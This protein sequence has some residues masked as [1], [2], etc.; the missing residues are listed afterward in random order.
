LVEDPSLL[1]FFEKTL[2]EYA[3]HQTKVF[4][5]ITNILLGKL[6]AVCKILEVTNWNSLT[7]KIN[8]PTKAT[9]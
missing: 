7:E 5:T 4:D 1:A 3:T 8:T 2:Q 6:E 9:S